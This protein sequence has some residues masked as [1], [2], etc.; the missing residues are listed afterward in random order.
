[1]T[2]IDALAPKFRK[3]RFNPPEA[4]E[5]LFEAH[6]VKVAVAT[7][8]KLRCVGGGPDFQKFGRAVLYPRDA[9]DGWANH[10]LGKA[11]A[12]TSEVA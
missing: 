5:Y 12:N 1:M 6:G 11:V 2:T 10:R 3:T 9:L 4:A 7:M 8:N